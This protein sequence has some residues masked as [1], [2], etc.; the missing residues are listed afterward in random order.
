MDRSFTPSLARR[1]AARQAGQGPDHEISVPARGLGLPDPFRIIE[2]GE[3]A[4]RLGRANVSFEAVADDADIG[5]FDGQG[6]EHA[7][8]RCG[9]GLSHADSALDLDVIEVRFKTEPLDLGAL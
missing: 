6:G 7:P 4:Q 3:T 9:R 5:D 2:D 1:K 8:E